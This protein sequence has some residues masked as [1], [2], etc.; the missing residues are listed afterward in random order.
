MPSL[1]P[2]VTPICRQPRNAFR[3]EQREDVRDAGLRSCRNDFLSATFAVTVAA[4][5]YLQP[6][7]FTRLPRCVVAG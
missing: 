2:Y 7:D 6:S 3:H 4:E 5:V 1:P